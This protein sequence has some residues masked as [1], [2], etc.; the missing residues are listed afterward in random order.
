[1]ALISYETT[2]QLLANGLLQQT[3]KGTRREM[4]FRPVVK[5][6]APGS[7]AV[8][9]LTEIDPAE[10]SIAFGL[11]DLGLGY[12]E[13]GSI[14]LDELERLCDPLGFKIEADET[15][16]ASKPLSQYAND[17]RKAGKITV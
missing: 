7:G 17:A 11:A 2:A 4:D 8:W 16:V 14:C 1:M 9:L 15:F 6:H 5:L 3:L 12:P 10:P 13:M